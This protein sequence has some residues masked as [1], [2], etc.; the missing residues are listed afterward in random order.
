MTDTPNTPEPPPKPNASAPVWELVIGDDEER[1]AYEKMLDMAPY[2][3]RRIEGEKA[4]SVDPPADPAVT[5]YGELNPGQW[6]HWLDIGPDGGPRLRT[7]SGHL[8]LG[9]GEV[10]GVPG[11]DRVR[12]LTPAEVA[13]HFAAIAG[14]SFVAHEE[15]EFFVGH[16][17]GSPIACLGFTDEDGDAFEHVVSV[18]EARG[19]V[20]QLSAWL[21]ALLA[22]GV[23]PTEDRR[24]DAPGFNVCPYA[25]GRYRVRTGEDTYS[26]PQDQS[27]SGAVAH[28]WELYDAA[29]G[30]AA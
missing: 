4:Q 30:G 5:T 29:K 8:V 22:Q 15:P 25:F 21:A 13:E 1:H 18:H 11:S 7:S 24:W 17:G 23:E 26:Y 14:G 6:F 16:S 3:R 27:R 12:R 9:G 10:T 19:L 2:L 28:S 20:A